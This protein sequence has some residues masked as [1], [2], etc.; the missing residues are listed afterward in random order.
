MCDAKTGLPAM[1]MESL[2]EQLRRVQQLWAG[3]GLIVGRL[4]QQMRAMPACKAVAEIP[5]IGLLTA[6]A[7]VA[8]KGTPTAFKYAREFAARIGLALDRPAPMG[9]YGSL[10]Q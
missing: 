2:D 4:S 8:S 10:A 5:G 6:T 1:L 9:G 3:I 7:V